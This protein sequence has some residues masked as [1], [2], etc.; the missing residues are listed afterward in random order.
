MRVDEYMAQDAT[1]LAALVA[2]G[3]VSADELLTAALARLDEVRGLNAI[4]VPMVEIGR[5][6]AATPLSGPFAG[7]PFLLKDWSQDY[8]GQPN[9]GGSRARE[10]WI[11]DRHSTYTQRCLDAGLVIFGRT[12]TP[13]LA[14]KAVTETALYGPT[15]NPWDERR[16]P[17]GSSGG[18]AAMVA[19]CVVPMAGA[20]DGGGSIRIPAG[21]C[22]LFGFR[23]GRGRMPQGPQAGEGWE[24][25]NSEGVL[26]RSV[27]DSAAMLDLLCGTDV[28]APFVH[29]RPAQPFADALRAE[30]GRLRIGMSLA[31]P[32]GAPVAGQAVDAVRIAAELLESL[33]HHVEPAEPQIDGAVLAQCFLALYVGQVAAD[34]E[35]ARSRTGARLSDFESDTLMLAKLGRAMPAG[36]YVTWRRRWNELARALADYFERYDLLLLPTTAGPPPLIHELD[37]PKAQMR[38]VSVLNRLP[39]GKLLHASGMLAKLAN[40]SLGRTPFTQLSNLTGTPSM[41]VPLHWARPEPHEPEVPYGVQFVAPVGEEARLFSLAAQLEQA[42]P[43]AHRRPGGADEAAAASRAVPESVATGR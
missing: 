12:T 42:A 16:S 13:E 30:P 18:A 40:D 4:A 21:Y 9:T 7:V 19:A 20:S 33:G 39:V 5:A 6:R 25:A 15:R 11:S 14:L 38:L 1:G 32:V 43:W 8:A 37:L 36:E 41:S 3:E 27:R 23:A 29:A 17:G 22:G 10:S 26:T 24:G 28:G 34:V 2:R 35:A 31:S